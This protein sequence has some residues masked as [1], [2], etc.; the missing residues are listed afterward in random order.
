MASKSQAHR[1]WR[2]HVLW[3]TRAGSSRTV[4]ARS[5]RLLST[6]EGRLARPHWLTKRISSLVSFSR[7]HLVDASPTSVSRH[8]PLWPASLQISGPARYQ[9]KWGEG[10]CVSA[11]GAPSVQ[12]EKLFE[13]RLSALTS[14][15]PDATVRG[16]T[17]YIVNMLDLPAIASKYW[18][19]CPISSRKSFGIYYERI[20]PLDCIMCADL[21]ANSLILH[22]RWGRG[23]ASIFGVVCL[24]G[25]RAG[26]R[27]LHRSDG[28]AVP[29]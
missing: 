14:Q 21:L 24:A 19:S 2:P 15:C 28:F 7:S 27:K 10:S 16:K 5:R 3:R 17:L 23:S 13:K 6:I 4:E 1:K 22:N 20:T 9:R 18:C 26:K 8:M 12:P 25:R 29:N 11:P